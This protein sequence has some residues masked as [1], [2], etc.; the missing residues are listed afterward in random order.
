MRRAL[1][2][3]T[4]RLATWV[5]ILSI[6]GLALASFLPW[7]SVE[8]DGSV[9]DTLH[10]NKEMMGKSDNEQIQNFVGHLNLINILFW[11]LIIFDLVFIIGM[12]IHATGKHPSLAPIMM[13]MGL[14]NLIFSIL[15]VILQIFFI[16]NVN[17]SSTVSLSS[18]VTAIHYAYIPLIFVIILLINTIIYTNVAVVPL[19]ALFKIS[20]KP[21]KKKTKHK[22]KKTIETKETE[23]I[24]EKEKPQPTFEKTA[25]I[26]VTNKKR[27][28]IEGWLTGQVY[29]VD[30][31]VK[32]EITPELEKIDEKPI[33]KI[34]GKKEELTEKPA[35]KIGTMEEA[36]REEL[37]KPADEVQLEQPA[38]A[39]QIIEKPTEPKE[40]PV[41]DKSFENALSAAI[42]KKQMEKKKE[43]PP[44][45]DEAKDEITEELQPE[46]KEE[47]AE[48]SK[49]PEQPAGE[50]PKEETPAE[51]TLP[52]LHAIPQEEARKAK[53][54]EES[55]KK[56]SIKC[57]QC[58]HKFSFES[59]ED[60]KKIKCPN[61]G[62]EGV[63]K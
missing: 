31:P 10:F 8:E 23:P 51:E 36:Q 4:I 40:P 44:K 29:K 57:P 43:E 26:P 9:K 21:P 35:E 38:P 11:L 18:I 56:I 50:P 49:E 2:K 17:D 32:N 7:V 6:I 24:I 14:G 46:V 42:E 20:A 39:K 34:E 27:T 3:R 1:A 58:S 12:I 5:V 63:L 60:T 15:I 16:K 48:E 37:E 47:K 13:L 41:P 45:E 62:K 19:I 33:E 28:E 59:S 25:A 53:V 30:K 54:E 55:N 22:P 52:E 61:C